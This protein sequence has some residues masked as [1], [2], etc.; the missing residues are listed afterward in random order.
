MSDNKRAPGETHLA[1]LL[2]RVLLGINICLHGATRIAAGESGF[3][4]KIESQF[5]HTVLPH[6]LIAAFAFSLPWAEAIIGC[7]VTVGL[8][9][10]SALTSGLLVMILLMFGTCL[11]QDWQTAGLQLIYG[12]AYAALLSLGQ[13]NRYS[14][15]SALRTK[16]EQSAKQP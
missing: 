14:V 4:G 11:V 12:F 1:Y 15:D 5:A 7:L 16:R 2:F 6:P 3:A 8:F 9:T 13:Y 10:R